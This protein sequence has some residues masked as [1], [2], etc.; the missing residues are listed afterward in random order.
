[1]RDAWGAVEDVSTRHGIDH[2]FDQIK[3][4]LERQRVVLVEGRHL[5]QTIAVGGGHGVQLVATP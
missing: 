2:A 5:P 3:Q 1:V 4:D